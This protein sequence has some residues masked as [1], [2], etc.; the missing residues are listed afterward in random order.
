ME[1]AEAQF[2]HQLEEEIHRHKK[3]FSDLKQKQ[4]MEQA[5]YQSRLNDMA[6]EIAAIKTEKATKQK[7]LPQ[8]V[9]YKDLGTL[10]QEVFN[11]LPGTVNVNRGGAIPPT[12]TSVN[13]ADSTIAPPNKQIYFGQRSSTPR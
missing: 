13:W 6:K 7:P 10:H 1:A 2:K 9:K 11:T 3:D 12:G 8:V 4:E 5:K